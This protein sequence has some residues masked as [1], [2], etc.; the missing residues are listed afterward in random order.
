MDAFYETFKRTAFIEYNWKV[1]D[2]RHTRCT[3]EPC[4]WISCVRL[5]QRGVR[6]KSWFETFSVE[7]FH[8][9]RTESLLIERPRP[10]V[11][12]SLSIGW[13]IWKKDFQRKIIRDSESTIVCTGSIQADPVHQ[14]RS[15]SS[16]TTADWAPGGSWRSSGRRALYQSCLRC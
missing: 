1:F 12:D 15:S 6:K 9:K 10:N 13:L 4:L 7:I 16:A 14:A 3:I 8:L 11:G 2:S 5:G